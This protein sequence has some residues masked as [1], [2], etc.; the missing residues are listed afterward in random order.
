MVKE[1]EEENKLKSSHMSREGNKSLAHRLTQ[2]V[3][4]NIP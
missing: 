4:S 2:K 1:K 3:G